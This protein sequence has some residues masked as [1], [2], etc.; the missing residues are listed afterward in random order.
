MAGPGSVP[1]LAVSGTWR[2]SIALRD[3]ENVNDSSPI[4]SRVRTAG[5]PLADF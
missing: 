5:A 2:G 4:E 1:G 3:D